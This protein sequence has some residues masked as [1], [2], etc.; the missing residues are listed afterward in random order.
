[1]YI[2][3]SYAQWVV[4]CVMSTRVHVHLTASSGIDSSIAL[5]FLAF[6]QNF[7]SFS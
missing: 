2:D 4:N 6:Q 7:I 3:E 1:M 5:H